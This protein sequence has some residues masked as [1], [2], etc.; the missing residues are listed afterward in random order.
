MEKKRVLVL[1]PWVPYPV[2][3]ACQQDR[4]HGLKQMQALG[5]DV[6]VIAKIHGWQPRAEAE[7]VFAREGIPLTLLPYVKDHYS[8]LLRRLPRILR[9]P[10][11]ID[12]AALEY[13]DPE[14]E[15]VVKDVIERFKP[16]LVWIE[17][18][19]LWPTLRL[20][21]HYGIPTIVKSSLNE[22]YNCRDENGWS[23]TSIIKSIPKYG[24]ETI[25]AK[26]SDFIFGITPVEEQWYRSRGAKHAGTLPLRGLSRCLV[27]K[28]H[29]QKDVLDVVF[30]SSNYNMGHNR[31]A[32]LFLLE[33][34]LPR[35]RERAPGAFRFHLTGSKFP[36]QHRHLLGNDANTTGF[37]PDIGEFLGTMDI[38]L[39]P[40]ISGHGMQQKV[41]EPLCRSLPLITTKTNGYPFEPGKEILLA[42]HPDEYADHLLLL[43]DASKR[44]AQADAAYAKSQMLFGEETVKRLVSEAISQVMA[45]K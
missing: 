14:Y 28:E 13:T 38:A 29:T 7:S 2:T 26:E 3:G 10:A 42:D 20:I 41:F 24:G 30:L 35:V 36:E 27:R 4:F 40:W 21:K 5:Y 19:P 39:C 17:Y 44:Q 45:R 11:L 32:L 16:D 31:D 22:P 8:L 33:K 9:T 6:H 15:Q 18:T 34:I 37:V 25:A 1:T 43:R 23:F 12:G